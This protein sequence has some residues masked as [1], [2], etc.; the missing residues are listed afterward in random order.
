[1]EIQIQRFINTFESSLNAST[2]MDKLDYSAQ[3]EGIL[4]RINNHYDKHR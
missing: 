1:M 4:M 3:L 2:E